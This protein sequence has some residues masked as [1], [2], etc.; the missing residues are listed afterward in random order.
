MTGITNKP[1]GQEHERQ[2][3]VEEHRAEL[4]P[5]EQRGLNNH[6]PDGKNSDQTLPDHGRATE[7]GVGRGTE[8]LNSE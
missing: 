5:P 3:I 7:T 6:A 1:E 4:L 8:L 2:Q